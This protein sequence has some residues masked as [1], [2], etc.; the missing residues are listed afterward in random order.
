MESNIADAVSGNG[1]VSP[2][3]CLAHGRECGRPSV[4][5]FS[6]AD[7]RG[8]RLFSGAVLGRLLEDGDSRRSPAAGA[9]TQSDRS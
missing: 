7:L 3:M 9:T 2:R 8:F 1:P 4:E 5:A 6:D